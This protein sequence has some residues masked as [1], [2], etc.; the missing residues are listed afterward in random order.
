MIFASGDPADNITLGGSAR[1][2]PIQMESSE[3]VEKLVKNNE[4]ESFC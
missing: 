3:W 4:T 1:A 2:E